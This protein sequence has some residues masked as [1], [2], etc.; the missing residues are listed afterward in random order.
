MQPNLGF[1][2]EAC[3]EVHHLQNCKCLTRVR[4]IG[5]WRR[6]RVLHQHDVKRAYETYLDDHLKLYETMS[7]KNIIY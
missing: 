1:D 7:F 4:M 2:E 5:E 3:E 6:N